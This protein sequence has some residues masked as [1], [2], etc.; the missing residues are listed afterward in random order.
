MREKP[1]NSDQSHTKESLSYETPESMLRGSLTTSKNLI[2]V[3]SVVHT[4]CS[5][6]DDSF[7][8]CLLV[9]MGTEHPW[10]VHWEKNVWKLQAKVLAYVF[11]KALSLITVARGVVTCSNL[12]LPNWGLHLVFSLT[13]LPKV[14]GLYM[15][16]IDICAVTKRNRSGV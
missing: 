9:I 1:A 2:P 15:N 6:S 4:L 11:S 14:N 10:L 8:G 16:G 13:Y 7:V 5:F 12:L 3:S